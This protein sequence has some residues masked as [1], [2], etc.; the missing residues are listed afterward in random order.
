MVD[1]TRS[2]DAGDQ[3]AQAAESPRL[4]LSLGS[5]LGLVFAFG[6]TV[7]VLEVVHDAER[8][9]FWVLSAIAMAALVYPVVEWLAHYRFVP[10]AVAVLITVIA[11]LGTLGFVGYRIVDDVSKAMSSLQSAAPERAGELEQ[12]SDFF[13]E[14]KLQDRVT[15]LVNAIPQRLAGGETTEALKS[16]ATRSVAFLAGLIL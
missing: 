13:R 16:A 3:T 6:A 9:I 11:A 4:R 2:V 10:R 5:A 14:I 15:K 1:A 8:V 7:L 12:N